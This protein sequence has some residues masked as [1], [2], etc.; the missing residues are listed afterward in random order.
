MGLLLGA[1]SGDRVIDSN[2]VRA[3]KLDCG[4]KIRSTNFPKTSTPT[5]IENSD[6]SLASGHDG[7]SLP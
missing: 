7:T 6:V 5:V 4:M 3:I 2:D 1:V